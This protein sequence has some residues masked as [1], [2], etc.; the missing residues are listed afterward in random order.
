MAAADNERGAINERSGMQVI[1]V[2]MYSYIYT[3]VVDRSIVKR[4]N[5]NANTRAGATCRLLAARET[6]AAISDC[7]HVRALPGMPLT[8]PYIPDVCPT[9]PPPT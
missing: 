4:V 9:L 3:A 7:L 6:G 5:V 2:C 1:R 8:L